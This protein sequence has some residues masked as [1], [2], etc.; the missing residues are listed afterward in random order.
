MATAAT[1]NGRSYERRGSMGH[2]TNAASPNNSL[3]AALRSANKTYRLLHGRYRIIGDINKG[4]YGSV[5]LARDSKRDDRLVAVKCISRASPAE[6]K[7]EIAI[8]QKLGKHPNIVELYDSFRGSDGRMY[9][10]MEYCAQGDLYEA[11][12]AGRGPADGHAV[13]DFMYQL[14]D[15]LEYCHSRSVFHRDIKPE[16]ILISADGRVKLADWGL[17]TTDRICTDFGV[18]SERYM[19]PELFDQANLAEYDA[20]KADVW[21]VG[22]CLVNILFERNPFKAAN[23]KDKLFLDFASSREALFDIFPN[24]SFDVFAVLRHALTIDPD[25]RSLANMRKELANVR[26][27]TTDDEELY[28][29]DLFPDG[30]VEAVRSD[31]EEGIDSGDADIGVEIGVSGTGTTATGVTAASGASALAVPARPHFERNSASKLVVGTPGGTEWLTTTSNRVPLRVVSRLG[32]STGSSTHNPSV[33]DG[34]SE[35]SRAMQFTPPTHDRSPFLRSRPPRVGGSS[36]AHEVVAEEDDDHHRHIDG[37]TTDSYVAR[38]ASPLATRSSQGSSGRRASSGEDLFQMDSLNNSLAQLVPAVGPGVASQVP[39]SSARQHPSAGAGPSTRN[40]S[41][42][43]ASVTSSVPSL[44]PSGASKPMP[45]VGGSRA[46]TTMDAVSAAGRT[47]ANT[48]SGSLAKAGVSQ[49]STA[50]APAPPPPQSSLLSAGPAAQPALASSAPAMNWFGKSWGDI[51]VDDDDDDFND[52]QFY[53]YIRAT[54]PASGSVGSSKLAPPAPADTPAIVKPK[55]SAAVDIVHPTPDTNQ[56][57][58]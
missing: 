45:V 33:G 48:Y 42:S 11:I 25:N 52:E 22:I 40:S 17:A 41:D 31:G 21:A 24:M 35:W 51:D 36:L 10:V 56:W 7:H 4:S 39:P 44:V 43:D 46:S 50:A 29:E 37:S 9:L 23:F 18:G 28:E 19:A 54:M 34:E 53:E 12:K 38:E 32:D 47:A 20:A 6:A 58:W 15:T 16:N 3:G 55:S 30:E 57:T 26:T 1:S 13:L 14:I 8:H 49:T 27:W 5:S 2:G